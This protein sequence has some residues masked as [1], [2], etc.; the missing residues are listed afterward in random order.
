MQ[1]LTVWYN[2]FC[3]DTEAQ[4]R[5]ALYGHCQP[6]MLFEDNFIKVS[7]QSLVDVQFYAL[8]RMLKGVELVPEKIEVLHHTP[9]AGISAPAAGASAAARGGDAA[10]GG[11]PTVDDSSSYKLRI[12]SQIRF[13]LFEWRRHPL[14]CVMFPALLLLPETITSWVTDELTVN[15]N[16]NKLVAYK[17]RIHNIPTAPTPVRWLLGLASSW[18]LMLLLGW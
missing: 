6:G 2:K 1:V 3:C 10:A 18:T 5:L 14:L 12:I 8:K 16:D 17:Q 7:G 15:N 11:R 4:Q 13:K 9:A